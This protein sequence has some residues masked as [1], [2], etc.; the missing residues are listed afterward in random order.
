M[1]TIQMVD[2]SRDVEINGQMDQLEKSL[3]RIGLHTWVGNISWL[4]KK[5]DV[6]ASFPQAMISN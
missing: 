4:E 6:I 1:L 3:S 2:W 5:Q